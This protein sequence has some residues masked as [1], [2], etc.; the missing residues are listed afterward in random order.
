MQLQCKARV[1]LVGGSRNLLH[2]SKFQNAENSI[3]ICKIFLNNSLKLPFLFSLRIKK[4]NINSLIGHVYIVDLGQNHLLEPTHCS[5]AFFP[6]PCTTISW[7]LIRY[8]K[9]DLISV[10]A[11][12]EIC[13]R[14]WIDRSYGSSMKGWWWCSGRSWCCRTA[15]C[16]RGIEIPGFVVDGYESDPRESNWTFSFLAYGEVYWH[17]RPRRPK[18]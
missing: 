12:S 17:W 11:C 13:R 5:W 14:W 18:L 2:T 7:W 6:T 3:Y 15:C 4:Y 9:M 10:L 1:N 8:N 16:P